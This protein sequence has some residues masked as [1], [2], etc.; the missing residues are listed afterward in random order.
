MKPRTQDEANAIVSQ[1]QKFAYWLTN[2]FLNKTNRKRLKGLEPE[3]LES[4]ALLA[5]TKAAYIWD[6]SQTRFTTYAGTAIVHAF[7]KA[8]QSQW[9]KDISDCSLDDLVSPSEGEAAR[10]GDFLPC[11]TMVQVEEEAEANL[12]ID[13]LPSRERQVVRLAFDGHG[14]TDIGREVGVSRQRI[15]QIRERA[16]K[17]LVKQRV[18]ST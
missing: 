11:Q 9:L 6:P 16:R 13:S 4:I 7:E 5:M 8:I 2:Q 15:N 12:I 3:D 18:F 1:N 14:E 10:L 17:R